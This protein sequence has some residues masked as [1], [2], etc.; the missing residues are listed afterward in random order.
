MKENDI[1][2]QEVSTNASIKPDEESS[3][4]DSTLTNS[5]V[6]RRRK[7]TGRPNDLAESKDKASLATSTRSRTKGQNKTGGDGD[8][9]EG[10]NSVARGRKRKIPDDDDNVSVMAK[11]PAKSNVLKGKARSAKKVAIANMSKVTAKAEA[12]VYD[13][14]NV[15]VAPTKSHRWITL[16]TMPKTC[17]YIKCPA[18]ACAVVRVIPNKDGLHDSLETKQPKN[19]KGQRELLVDRKQKQTWEYTFAMRGHAMKCE[20]FQNELGRAPTN[21]DLPVGIRSRGYNKSK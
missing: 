5:S 3:M 6:A 2:K 9:A 7:N 10:S 13:T 12:K 16:H 20:V 15:S 4:H 21:D 17:I 18:K 11:A 19:V 1:D 8:S 14:D